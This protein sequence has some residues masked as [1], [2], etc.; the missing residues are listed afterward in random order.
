MVLYF[1]F[2]RGE[3]R[4]CLFNVLMLSEKSSDGQIAKYNVQTI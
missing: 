1:T 3:N 4:P 2:K